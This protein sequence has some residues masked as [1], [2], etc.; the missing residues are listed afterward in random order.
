[1]RTIEMRQ[2][3]KIACVEEVAYHMGYIDRERL[4]SLAGIWAKASMPDTSKGCRDMNSDH[5][6]FHSGTPSTRNI[7]SS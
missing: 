7:S 4:L 2:G 6:E 1:M 3:L 5:R